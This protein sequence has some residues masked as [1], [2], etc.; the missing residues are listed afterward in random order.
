MKRFHAH[1]YF[2]PEALAYA[3][4]M[5][6]EIKKNLNEKVTFLKVYSTPVGP[7]PLPMIEIHFWESDDALVFQWL[8]HRHQNLSVLIH[9]DTGDDVKDHSS[10]IRWLGAPV[11]ID[12]DFFELILSRPDLRVHPLIET[13]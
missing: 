6:N 4:E 10:G 7:H 11:E 8:K 12:F 2:Q 1:L 13:H 5:A 9:E 3:E